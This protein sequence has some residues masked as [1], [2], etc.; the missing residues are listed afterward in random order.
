MDIKVLI[1]NGHGAD[2][3]GKCS[4]DA[5]KGLVSSPYWFK[6]YKW[7]REIARSLASIL[8]AQG[9]DVSL[10]VPEET[11]ISLQERTR[12]VNEYC[13]K[14]GRNNVILVSLHNN[15]A[16]D[17]GRWMTARGWAVYTSKGVTESDILADFLIREAEKEF[18]A[19]LKV[20]KY[21]D[22]YLEKDYEENFYI[23]KNTQ[24]PA[25]L[26]ENFFQDNKE[27]VLY[28]K[29]DKGKGQILYVLS[30]GIEN[31]LRSKGFLF[32]HGL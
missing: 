23:L 15:A 9:I 24:C 5:L 16:G 29:S 26:V 17:Q 25:V 20:R 6:E 8:Y 1:D 19:P 11:D 12:R 32:V 27:D 10:L 14:Y 13:E 3:K 22:K 28:L 30:V 31:Y 21:L 4:P 18:Q 2:T 7:C